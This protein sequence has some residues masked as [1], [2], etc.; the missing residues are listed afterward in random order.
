[1]YNDIGRKGIVRVLK[2]CVTE[3]TFWNR[4]FQKDDV[5]DVWRE[6]NRIIAGS[7]HEPVSFDA[8]YLAMQKFRLGQ[9]IDFEKAAEDAISF[10]ERRPETVLEEREQIRRPRR[11]PQQ[12]DARYAFCRSGR[13]TSKDK[14]VG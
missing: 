6:V 1:M 9:R 4:H 5:I 12:S 11:R 14:E 10:L 13:R 8:F 7:G 2:E 3:G